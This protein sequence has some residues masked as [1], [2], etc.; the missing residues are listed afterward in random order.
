MPEL[1]EVET[2]RRG[3]SPALV[4]QRIV[5]AK[6][7]VPK[8]RLPIPADFETRLRGAH[9]TG[10]ERRAKYIVM[11]CEG[12]P[13]V[14][15]HLGMS[16]HMTV[17][18]HN[19]AGAWE[20]QKHDHFMLL[21]ESGTRIVFNDARRFGLVVFADE[22]QAHQHTLLRHLGP[23]PLSA[24]F[25]ADTL[26]A[27]LAGRKTPVKVALLDQKLVVGVGN[28]YASEALHRARISPRRQ[29]GNVGAAMSKRLAP[30]IVDVL[31]EAIEAGGSTLR[32]H[33][34]VDGELGYFQ[35]R[36]RVYDREGAVCPTDGCSGRI[37]RIAQAGRST[38]FCSSCQR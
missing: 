18:G 14:I 10:L 9:I 38:Y 36:F 19:R 23:E 13:D 22:G 8:L 26:Q 16:G 15:I 24:D 4:G 32:D 6:A 37:R 12:G 21:T 7:Y 20:R 3:L 28:I 30:A 17:L 25:G 35:H 5:E 29:S 34:Q 11:A 27:M 31:N 1:P 33:A 2:V